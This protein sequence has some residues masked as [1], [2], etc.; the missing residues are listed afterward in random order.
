MEEFK[1][2]VSVGASSKLNGRT[3]GGFEG[4]RLRA[5][6]EPDVQ[7]KVILPILVNTKEIP[8]KGRLFFFEEPEKKPEHAP[9][10]PLKIDSVAE[11]KK[12]LREGSKGS[13]A[14]PKKR[15]RKS[16]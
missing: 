9:E 12:N 13:A 3:D 7:V 1:M 4:A 6:V 15:P 11:W 10:V 5:C 2:E 14:K 16:G 8:A